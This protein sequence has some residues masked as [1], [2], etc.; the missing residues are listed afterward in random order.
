MEK[1]KIT[2]IKSR[3]NVRST[4]SSTDFAKL[5]RERTKQNKKENTT[6]FVALVISRNILQLAKKIDTGPESAYN[7][8]IRE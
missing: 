4:L 3:T 2:K 5:T 6:A 8:Y 1:K 7:A